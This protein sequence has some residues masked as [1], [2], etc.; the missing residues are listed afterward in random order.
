MPFKAALINIF[1]LAIDQTTAECEGRLPAVSFS[2]NVLASSSCGFTTHKCPFL[3][4]YSS[5]IDVVSSHGRQENTQL[6]LIDKGSSSQ[7]NE[8][9]HF[10]AVE[11]ES[12]NSLRNFLKSK[13][14]L[15]YLSDIALRQTETCLQWDVY[16]N[17]CLFAMATSLPIKNIIKN[18]AA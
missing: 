14:R 9:W 10:I 15:R 3:F 11:M 16:I 8:V 18:T 6:G 4:D 1:I 13:P 5:L 2:C 12:G 7:V 17:H